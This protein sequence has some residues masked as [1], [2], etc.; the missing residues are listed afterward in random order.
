MTATWCCSGSVERAPTARRLSATPVPRAPPPRSGPERDQRIAAPG[1]RVA[2]PLPRGQLGGDA[3][4]TGRQRRHPGDEL[5]GT[6]DHRG[7]GAGQRS[8]RPSPWPNSHVRPMARTHRLPHPESPLDGH[9]SLEAR[10]GGDGS[11]ARLPLGQRTAARHE[12]R[13]TVWAVCGPSQPDG[14]QEDAAR[15]RGKPAGGDRSCEDPGC[16]SSALAAMSGHKRPSRVT[17]GEATRPPDWGHHGATSN[18]RV[19]RQHMRPST[20]PG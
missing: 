2:A 9:A 19:A 10:S 3:I 15:S 1:P 8:G 17:A 6:A 18:Q 7:G 12:L 11:G 14:G 5:A 20:A 13:R 16:R 4:G